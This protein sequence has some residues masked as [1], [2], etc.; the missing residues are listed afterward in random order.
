ME[1]QASWLYS[2]Q[3]EADLSNFL[4]SADKAPPVGPIKAPLRVVDRPSPRNVRTSIDMSSKTFCFGIWLGVV[5]AAA[6][7]GFTQRSLDW[8][9]LEVEARLDADGVLHVRETHHMVFDGEWNGGE[10]LFNLGVGRLSF[11]TLS[12]QGAGGTVHP[13]IRGDLDEID[14]W[15]FTEPGVLRWRSRLPTDPPFDD[16]TLVYVL[17]YRLLEIL[18][19]RGGS[20]FGGREYRFDHDFAF[21]DRAGDIRNFR[22]TFDLDPVWAASPP[23]ESPASVERIRPGSGYLVVTTLTHA[24]DRDLA[25]VHYPPPRWMSWVALPLLL[26]VSA[27]LFAQ[28]VRG[29]ISLGRWTPVERPDWGP[30]EVASKLEPWRAEELGFLWDQKVGPPE[31]AATIARMVADG[32]LESEVEEKRTLGLFKRQVL[33]LRRNLDRTEYPGYEGKLVRKLF[34]RNRRNV[35]TDQLRKHYRKTKSGLDLV[36]LID[37]DIEKAVEKK[38]DI[39]DLRSRP[40]ARRTVL[41]LLA[42]A[43]CLLVDFVLRVDR[44]VGSNSLDAGLFMVLGFVTVVLYLPTL[45]FAS[46]VQKRIDGVRARGTLL[47]L[48]PLLSAALLLFVLW[49][50]AAASLE[51]TLFG[52]VGTGLW[53]AGLFSSVLHMATS[54]LSR[55]GVALRREIARLRVWCVHELAQREPQL[56]DEWFAVLLAF[57]LERNVDGWFESFGGTSSTVGRDIYRPSTTTSAVGSGG[58]SSWTGGGGAFGGAGATAA[59]AGA[60]AAMGAGVASS[61]SSSSGGGSSGGGGG[62]SGG[63]GGGGW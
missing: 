22:L 39:E 44:L 4:Y 28:F 15:N 31:V 13:L 23:V 43:I 52:G 46:A 36:G 3:S 61:S 29:T 24:E 60:A 10:R 55:D 7:P 38:I 40:P 53:I 41:L 14:R 6:L 33:A 62:S 25:G 16:D 8:D 58:G 11:R 27:V 56:R 51:M 18:R 50:L 48:F 49:R 1:L 54:R 30:D 17:E 59:W 20:D 34:Y 47:L 5:A 21:T 2:L 26:L 63:G 57:G 9:R 32:R 19:P 37:D 12:R 45:G 35:D 42:A